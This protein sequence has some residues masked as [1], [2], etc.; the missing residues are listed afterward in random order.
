MDPV[1]RDPTSYANFKDCATEHI[2]LKWTV[3][4]DRQIISGCAILTVNVKTS[5]QELVL[6]IY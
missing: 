6:Y 4:F 2:C 3:D 5:A 1:D